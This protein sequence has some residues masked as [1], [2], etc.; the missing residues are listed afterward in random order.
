MLGSDFC[1]LVGSR[2]SNSLMSSNNNS[3]SKPSHLI[4]EIY[5]RQLAEETS[6]QLRVHFQV[7]CVVFLLV[8]PDKTPGNLKFDHY[9]SLPTKLNVQ[10]LLDCSVLYEVISL[11]DI[12][13]KEEIFRFTRTWCYSMH[14]QCLQLQGKWIHKA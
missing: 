5:A 6:Q 9:F 8:F 1:R 10:L 14:R 11:N 4:E 3:K 13:I 12:S 2:F 7:C